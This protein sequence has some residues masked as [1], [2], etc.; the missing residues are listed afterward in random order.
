MVREIQVTVVQ[1]KSVLSC[2]SR[3]LALRKQR[4]SLDRELNICGCL[5]IWRDTV[6]RGCKFLVTRVRARMAMSLACLV[7]E[8]Q[9]SFGR[10]NADRS[11]T[12][13]A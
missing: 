8:K 4:V 10:I 3:G 1:E 5:Q 12:G 6:Y 7:N 13:L 2:A 11:K 9:W